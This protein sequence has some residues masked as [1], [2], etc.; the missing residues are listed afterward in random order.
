MKTKC[1][2]I[3]VNIIGMGEPEYKLVK[4]VDYEVYEAVSPLTLDNG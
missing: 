2:S 4:K 3:W 1:L